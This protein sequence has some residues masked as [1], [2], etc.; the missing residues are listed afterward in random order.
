MDPRRGEIEIYLFPEE[1]ISQEFL[2]ALP[3]KQNAGYN[4]FRLVC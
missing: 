2:Q 4:F 3:T 1:H